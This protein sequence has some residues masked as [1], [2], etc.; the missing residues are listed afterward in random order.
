MG[1][2]NVDLHEDSVTV[3]PQEELQRFRVLL[4]TFNATGFLLNQIESVL[5]Q[6]GVDIDLN[7]RDDGSTNGTLD[8]L[9]KIST[10]DSR[11]SYI[12]GSRLGAAR[13]FLTMLS[14]CSDDV[15]LVALCDQDDVWKDEKLARAALWLS[16]VQ[17]P[18]MY[19][20]AVDIVGQRLDKI[21]IHRTCVRGPSLENAL[22]QNIATGCT[23]VLNQSALR[24]FR[25]IPEHPIMHDSWIYAVMSAC[26]TVLYDPDTWVLYRQHETNT[27][28]VATSRFRQWV[29]RIHRHAKMGRERVHTVQATELLELLGQEFT[30]SATAT[31]TRFVRAQASASGRI[32]Y[33]LTGPAFRQ[34]RLDSIVYRILC[35][36]GRI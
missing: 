9:R 36:L 27:I 29:G 4:S 25:T 30:P 21:G 33:A 34:R 17:G 1:D 18:A 13:S 31:V 11:V 32:V 14:E 24:L 10:D 26:G 35:A 7:I 12:G 5:G 15:G 16:A 6:R 8:L 28:G 22:V 3:G 19:C 20:S 23:I 2:L